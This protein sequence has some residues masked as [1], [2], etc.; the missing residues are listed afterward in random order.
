MNFCSA[1]KI[2]LPWEV[3]VLK[4][5]LIEGEYKHTNRLKGS[6]VLT[7]KM[8]TENLLLLFSCH[9]PHSS[10]LPEEITAFLHMHPSEGLK[11]EERVHTG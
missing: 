4:F 5:L 6:V 2:L 3:L 11:Q 8:D 7:V 9:Q 1:Q 10:I